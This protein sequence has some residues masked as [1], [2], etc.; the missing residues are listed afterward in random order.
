MI[1]GGCQQHSCVIFLVLAQMDSIA[2]A[3]PVCGTF[4]SVSGLPSWV[5]VGIFQKISLRS[6]KLFLLMMWGER[7]SRYM[8]PWEST[9]HSGE[10]I[11]CEFTQQVSSILCHGYIEK[12]WCQTRSSLALSRKSQ[13]SV[14]YAR[15]K[16][17]LIYPLLCR[18]CIPKICSNLHTPLLPESR[19]FHAS[20]GQICQS[21]QQFVAC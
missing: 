12:I 5:K 9:R 14:P 19:S 10:K 3:R 20:F 1:C 4:C 13:R 11:M 8:P 15:G 18:G 6:T 2:T 21:R 7:I 17:I 16:I